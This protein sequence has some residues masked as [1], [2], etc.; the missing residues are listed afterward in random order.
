MMPILIR[1]LAPSTRGGA[2]PKTLE[3]APAAAALALAVF[4]KLRRENLFL[5]M[6]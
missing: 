5:S 3:A 2:A 4:M 6:R 1:S